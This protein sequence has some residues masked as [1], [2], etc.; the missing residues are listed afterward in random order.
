MTRR[1]MTTL[2]RLSAPLPQPVAASTATRGLHRPA[3]LCAAIVAALGLLSACATTSP[4]AGADAARLRVPATPQVLVFGGTGMIGG[5]VVRELRRRGVP[6]T[7]F[8]RPSSNRTRLQDAGVGFVTGDVEDAASVSAALSARHYDV[9]ISA[10]ARTDHDTATDRVTIYATGNDRITTAARAAG[11]TQLLQIGTVGAGD[12]APLVPPEI[13][14]FVRQVMADKTQAEETLVASGLRYTIVRTGVLLGGEPTGK[15]ELS[16]DHGVLAPMRVADIAR[17][18]AA[19][20]GA[21]RC[22][23]RIY[24]TVDPTLLA[25]TPAEIAVEKAKLRE[26][27][28]WRRAAPATAISPPR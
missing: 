22:Y 3:G 12:S 20:V 28:E 6:V 10:I 14:A 5:E 15:G 1:D 13:R 26:L 8:V 21:P 4:A 18:V 19:C 27:K 11:V 23:D 9:V 7:V 2:D 17:E 16:E 25:L 24:H